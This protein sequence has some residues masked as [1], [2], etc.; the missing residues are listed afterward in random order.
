[1]SKPVKDML[2]RNLRQRFEGVR[3]VAVVDLT[4]VDATQTNAIRGRL[5]AKDIHVMVVKNSVARDAFRS[6]GLEVAVPLLDGPCAVA[7]GGD[8]VVTVVRELLAI[9]KETPAL[10]VKAAVL[11]G[12]PFGADRVEEL[13]KFPT[14]DEAIAKVVSCVLAPGSKLAGCLQAPG[15]ALAGILKTIEEKQGGGDEAAA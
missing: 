13:S 8:S 12:E 7:Y 15:A 2:R 5:R 14:R 10:T 1:M 3:S 9:H 6:V 4:G 11:E